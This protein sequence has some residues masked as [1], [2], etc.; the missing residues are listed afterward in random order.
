[1]RRLGDETSHVPLISHEHDLLL[2]ALDGIE[3]RAE[4]ARDISHRQCL[5]PIRLSD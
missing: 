4:V 1:M 3:N 2:V 5:H